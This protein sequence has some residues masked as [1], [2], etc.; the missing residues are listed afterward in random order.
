MAGFCFTLLHTVLAKYLFLL[1]MPY[2]VLKVGYLLF[3]T[4]PEIRDLT[5]TLLTEVCS[6]VATEAELQP[7]SQKE[8]SLST[9]NVQDGDKLNIAINGFWGRS[10][11]AFLMFIFLIRLLHQMQPLPYQLAIRSKKHKEE[12]IWTKD[13]RSGACFIYSCGYVGHQCL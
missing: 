2:L 7:I 13:L 8:F 9:A 12:S 4:M 11:L 6:Q 5:A 1:N 3:D 10:E